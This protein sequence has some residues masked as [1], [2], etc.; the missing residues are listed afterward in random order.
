MKKKDGFG[1]ATWKLESALTPEKRKS[2]QEKV[3]PCQAS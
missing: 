1:D 3:P 2:L